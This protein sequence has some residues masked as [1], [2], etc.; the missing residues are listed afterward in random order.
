MAHPAVMMRRNIFVQHNLYY[1]ESF[2]HAEDYELWTRAA[3]FGRMANIP[4][5]LLLYRVSDSQ[6]TGFF[7][8]EQTAAAN[9]V[10]LRQITMLGIEPSEQERLMHESITGSLF[11]VPT[12]R[13]SS[14]YAW[15]RKLGRANRQ[16]NVFPQRRFSFLLIK[17][18]V[19]IMLMRFLAVVSSI[20]RKYSA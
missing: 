1:D 16:R 3:R 18:L 2:R 10:R 15:L 6:V 13:F 12:A 17:L 11:S 4:E 5:I 20:R 8:K 19:K 14:Y 7:K 9:R